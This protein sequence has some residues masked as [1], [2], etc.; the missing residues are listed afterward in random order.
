MSEKLKSNKPL[1]DWT[2]PQLKTLLR[3]AG[4]SQVGDFPELIQ[5]IQTAQETLQRLAQRIKTE[6]T[7]SGVLR[8]NP[9]LISEQNPG[10]SEVAN[11]GDDVGPRSFP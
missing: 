9:K 3:E 5:R 11:L 6:V 4:L 1:T 8:F 10:S 7:D 2:K